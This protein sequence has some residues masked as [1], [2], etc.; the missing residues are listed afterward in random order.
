M[1][2]LG[3]S[4]NAS[5]PDEWRDCLMTLH[6]SMWSIRLLEEPMYIDGAVSSLWRSRRSQADGK[7]CESLLSVRVPFESIMTRMAWPY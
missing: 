2:R 4:E 3:P 6:P 7:V 1:I 5:E